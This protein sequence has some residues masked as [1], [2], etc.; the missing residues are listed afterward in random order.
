MAASKKPGQATGVPVYL[1]RRVVWF[2][3]MSVGLGVIAP[4]VSWLG[5]GRMP[6]WAFIAA[7]S[8]PGIASGFI[9][10]WYGM[11]MTREQKRAAAL[12]GRVCWQCGYSLEGIGAAGTCPECGGGYDVAEL[13][14]RWGVDSGISGRA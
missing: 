6:M 4:L 12:G 10:S 7:V 9:W 11:A 14:T 5:S 8:I 13:R 2:V 1:R 3:L